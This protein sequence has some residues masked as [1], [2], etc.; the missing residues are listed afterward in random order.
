[1]SAKG[2]VA[3]D[4]RPGDLPSHLLDVTRAH[5][6]TDTEL[7]AAVRVVL[8]DDAG[9]LRAYSDRQASLWRGRRRGPDV[10]TSWI[11]RAQCAREG[12]VDHPVPSGQHCQRCGRLELNP[13]AH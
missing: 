5:P 1:M 2:S 11:D 8:G 3:S 13:D 9:S 7:E 12:H 10:P 4:P 6:P